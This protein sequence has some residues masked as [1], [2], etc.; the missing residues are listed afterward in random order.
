MRKLARDDGPQV[1]IK[2][3]GRSVA[4]SRG[5]TVAAAL[6]AGNHWR[7]RTTPVSGAPR[8]PYCMMG[9]CFDCLVEIDGVANRQACMTEVREG[10]QVQSQQGASDITPHLFS[11]DDA[12]PEQ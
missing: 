2:F 11:G 9:V 8:G 6:L 12:E 4:A 1:C 5:D 10:M 7:F 3:D